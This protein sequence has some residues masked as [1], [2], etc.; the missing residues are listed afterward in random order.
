MKRR[1]KVLIPLDINKFQV[2][3]KMW[4]RQKDRSMHIHFHLGYPDRSQ[5]EPPSILLPNNNEPKYINGRMNRIARSILL[6]V[7]SEIPLVCCP[8]FFFFFD[9]ASHYKL[10][11]KKVKKFLK[12]ICKNSCAETQFD[13]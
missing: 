3:Q 11:T 7:V 2:Q 4:Q 1:G 8:N 12:D 13:Y 10:L 9:I 5:S 6:R